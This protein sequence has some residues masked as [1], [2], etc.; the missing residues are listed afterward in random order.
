MASVPTVSR[1]I[2]VLAEDGAKAIQAIAVARQR[3][4]TRV[5]DLARGHAPD[6]NATVEDPLIVDLDASPLTVPA[7]GGG[8]PRTPIS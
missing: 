8:T 5:W 2:K 4:R 3:A 7:V 6:H 1:L